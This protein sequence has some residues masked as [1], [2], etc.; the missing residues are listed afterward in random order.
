MDAAEALLLTV[1]TTVPSTAPHHSLIVCCTGGS[2]EN[3][4]EIRVDSFYGVKGGQ[5]SRLYPCISHIASVSY[6]QADAE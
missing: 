5:K 1:N 2:P 4:R 3:A 6:H